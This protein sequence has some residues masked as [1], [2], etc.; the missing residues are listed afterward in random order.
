MR[1]TLTLLSLFIFLPLGFANA[2]ERRQ[3]VFGQVEAPHSYYWRGLY[4]PH[5]TTG[6]SA[7]TFS[8]DGNEVVYSMAGSLWRQK[9]GN[10]NAF[11]L[12]SDKGY[13]YQPD[14]SRGGETVVFSRRHKDAMELYSLNLESGKTKKLTEF[15]AVSIEPRISPDG[16]KLAFVS[17]FKNGNF[18]LYVAD[19]NGKGLANIVPIIE[20]R[21]S[22][23]DRYYYGELDHAI[24][25]SWSPD[26]SRLL[27]V[28]NSEVAWGTGDIWSVSVEDP[29]DKKLVL[30][31]ETTWDA[32]PE[33]APDGKRVLYSSYRGRQ[34]H[35]L[36]L[37]TTDGMP[38]FP[39]TF[40]DFDRRNARWSL[41]AKKII[42]TSNEDGNLSLWVQNFIGGKKTNI[43]PL[44]RHY[45]R[46]MDSIVLKVVDDAGEP[47]S[48]RVSVLSKVTGRHYGANDARMLADDSFMP[49]QQEHE[50]HYFY[51][52]Q[53]C[54]VV[55]PRGKLAISVYK[56]LEHNPDN[57]VV[58][59]KKGGL[60]KTIS[61][62]S[63]ALPSEYGNFLSAEFHH[64]MNYG[65]QYRMTRESMAADAQAEGIDIVYNLIVNKE[66]RI[67]SIAEFTPKA[68]N[69][70]DV[71]VFQGQETHTS[72]WGH[73]GLL[74]LDD[75]IVMPD[76]SSYRHTA[77][78]SPYPHNGILS[79]LAHEQGALVGY[80]HP[81]D[82]W[83]SNLDNVEKLTHT[84]PVDVALGKTDYLEVVSFAD[85][86]ATAGV[87]YRL[88]NLGFH[89][90]AGAGT[91]SM[92][93]LA[94]F[95]GPI[96][97]NR[98]YLETDSREPGALK[99]AIKSGR[100]FVTNGPLLGLKINDVA[101]GGTINVQPGRQMVHIRASMRSI[102]PVSE[103]ELVQ[104]GQV[105]KTLQ[106]SKDGLSADFD[107]ELEIKDGGWILLRASNPQAH[108]NI[109]DYYPYGTTNPV[110]LKSPDGI[111][112]AHEDARYFMQWI[113][114][115][116]KGAAARTDYNSDEE[117]S[118][119]LGY[120]SKARKVFEEKSLMK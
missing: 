87:W 76:F 86:K 90:P 81:F 39:L 101:P 120:L 61:L 54:E 115:V 7:G 106:V 24:N 47:I 6:P 31:E 88:M 80:V 45:K 13:D 71:T 112:A 1:K 73:L 102:A 113:D 25:P 63:N 41:D 119:T 68:T 20:G 11:E 53:S 98:V 117:R 55:A 97:L 82:T 103:V 114:L 100:G 15:G 4:L 94:S 118:N 50:T 79:D 29:K 2:E 8:P 84:L 48:A 83:I 21:R 26:G 62:A 33:T 30:S 28:N 75:R 72:Y 104:N 12:T 52:D 16:T 14:W 42:Y 46:G 35:Q 91:D 44:K 116:M 43:K 3:P 69:I 65:G 96:G 111:P 51:C 5:L 64:H 78:A 27:Y 59:L 56:G 58:E 89:L 17:S 19:L 108:I 49:E 23:I 9:I 60:V 32:R 85:H 92:G 99:D 22:K 109:Q 77:L 95:R 36:W 105:I 34:W 66:E 18:N 110:W 67:P 40:G 57:S 37:T 93:N 107:G 10:N 70:G 74:H 38:P